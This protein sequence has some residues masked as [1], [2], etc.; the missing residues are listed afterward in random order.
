MQ[1]VEDS[2]AA[3]EDISASVAITSARRVGSLIVE[4]MN[5]GHLE[6]INIYYT[7]FLIWYIYIIWYSVAGPLLR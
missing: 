5:R 4:S 3:V 1:F 7:S 2:R 6:Y